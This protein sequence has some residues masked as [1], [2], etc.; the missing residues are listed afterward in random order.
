ML[1]V[2]DSSADKCGVVCS[3]Y[4]ILAAHLLSPGVRGAEGGHRGKSSTGSARWRRW[5]DLLFRST[6]A[7]RARCRLLAPHLRGDQPRGRRNHR[8]GERRPGRRVIPE[9]APEHLPPT[10]RLAI[11]SPEKLPAGYARACAGS[12]V[13][14]RLVMARDHARRGARQ[15]S[16]RLAAAAACGAQRAASQLKSRC[17]H[18]GPRRRDQAPV[19]ADL[20]RPS[21]S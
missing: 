2:K 3:S 19:V 20:I 17:S 18:P 16:P 9:L 5:A 6:R 8:D 1:V 11:E 10:S 21:L 13:A 14:T 4:E 15:G 7:F 12:F